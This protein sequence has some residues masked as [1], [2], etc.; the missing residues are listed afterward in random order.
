ML[1]LNKLQTFL[2]G[3]LAIALFYIINRGNQLIGTEQVEGKLLYYVE[4]D[5]NI[6]RGIEIYPVIGFEYNGTAHE[7]N[8]RERASYKKDKIIPI[9][10]KDKNPKEPIIYT[11]GTFWLYPLF[12]C[13]LPLLIWAAFSLS[14]IDKKEQLIIHLKYPFFKK[15]GKIP[16]DTNFPSINN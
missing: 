7:F 10:V 12:Y 2:I 15:E 1:K 6:E 4:V 5:T 16:P 3:L 8:G 9:L 11:L 13:L 14:Y